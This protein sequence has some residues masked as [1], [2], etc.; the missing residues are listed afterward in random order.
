LSILHEIRV[1]QV[2]P[3]VGELVAE[4]EGQV[5]A[6]AAIEIIDHLLAMDW[7]VQR[8]ILDGDF[9]KFTASKITSHLVAL[10]IGDAVTHLSI[11]L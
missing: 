3:G 5:G 1:M 2:V 9:P 8:R 6:D 10:I 11:L 4:A 7:A